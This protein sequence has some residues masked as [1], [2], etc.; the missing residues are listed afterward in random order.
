MRDDGFT[1]LEMLI[2]L[3][4]IALIFTLTIPN[5][6]DRMKS[7]R[8]KGCDAL[9]EV[10]NTAILQYELDTGEVADSVDELIAEGYLKESQ[11]ECM[12]GSAITINDGQAER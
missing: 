2:V 6:Q 5:I 1:M 12:D 8:D 9:V 4:I 11:G 10:V 7:V 3:S